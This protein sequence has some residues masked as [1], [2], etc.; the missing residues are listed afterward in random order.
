MFVLPNKVIAFDVE[1]TGLVPAYDHPLSMSAIVFEDG[2]PTGEVFQRKMY[3]GMRAKMSFEALEV[4]GG[5]IKDN[6][7]AMAQYLE[8]VFPDDAISAKECLVQFA[9]WTISNGFN[10]LPV[11]AQKA[12]FDWGF[13]N[14]KLCINRSV[15]VGNV[16]S[17]MWICTKT[18]ASHLSPDKSSKSLD[19]LC[20]FLGI[21]GRSTTAHD[22]YEDALKCG[23][24]Y[25]ALKKQW[26]A[27]TQGVK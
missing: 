6:R 26:E 8:R 25:F 4:Q 14:E 1:S 10:V 12:E 3:P 19:S 23:E 13:F 5:S 18:L 7:E 11:V 27:K 2:E 15:H 21:E 24:V 9:E 16:L 22:S 20:A 17:P